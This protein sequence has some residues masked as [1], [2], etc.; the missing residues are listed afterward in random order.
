MPSP[1][2]FCSD[3]PSLALDK[4]ERQAKFTYMEQPPSS[5]PSRWA[6]PG[7]MTLGT[8]RAGT[9]VAATASN[10]PTGLQWVGE[11]GLAPVGLPIAWGW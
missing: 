9:S 11:Q 4:T 8:P 10:Q 5:A 3:Q 6:H 1:L 2:T 7:S